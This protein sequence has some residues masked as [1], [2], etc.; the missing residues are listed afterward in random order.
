M[1]FKILHEFPSPGLEQAWREYLKHVGVPSHYDSPEYFLDPLR[2]G[3][4]PFAVLALDGSRIRGTLTGFHLDRAVLSGLVS[5]PQ[6][7]VDGTEVAETLDTLAQGLKVEAK[8]A[9]LISVY[10]WS[11]LD[12]IPFGSHGFRRRQLLGSVVLD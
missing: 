7:S 11:T 4:R 8:T 1:N 5:R 6:I 9:E 3:S 2:Q 12:L 10:S